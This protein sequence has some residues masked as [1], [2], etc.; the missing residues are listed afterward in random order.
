MCSSRSIA[1]RELL[2]REL[3]RF[4]NATGKI[5]TLSD[6]TDQFVTAMLADWRTRTIISSAYVFVLEAEA[7]YNELFLRSSAG[8]SLGPAIGLLFRG[9]LLLESLLKHLYPARSNGDANRTMGRIFSDPSFGN[10]FVRELESRCSA[11]SIA[12]VIASVD[13]DTLESALLTTARLRNTTGHNLI[14]D[15]AFGDPSR[16]RVLVSQELNALFYVIR[17]RCCATR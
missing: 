1:V 12:N 7:R 3:E 11:D 15:D 16:F 10:D 9:G 17:R 2:G 14:W 4:S 13:Q 5:P 6:Y 8:G